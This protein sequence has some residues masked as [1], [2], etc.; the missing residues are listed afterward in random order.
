MGEVYGTGTFAPMA[1]AHI[2]YFVVYVYRLISWT[3]EH[4]NRVAV[5]SRTFSVGF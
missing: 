1:G 3:S 2:D 4:G 5:G